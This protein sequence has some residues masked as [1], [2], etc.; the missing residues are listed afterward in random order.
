MDMDMDDMANTVCAHHCKM[1][2]QSSVSNVRTF[3]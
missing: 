1:N 2:P 3:A